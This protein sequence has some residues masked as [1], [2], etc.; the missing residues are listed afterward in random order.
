[1]KIVF[2]SNF[3]NHH[4]KPFSDELFRL[5]PDYYFVETT[6]V[7]SEQKAMGYQADVNPSYVLRYSENKVFCE[8]LVNDADAVIIG[9]APEYLIKNRKKNNKIVI[10]YCERPLKKK[11]TPIRYLK[12]LIGMNLITPFWKPLYML[13]ASAYTASDFRLFGLYIGKTYKW[14]YFTEVKNFVEIDTLIDAKEKK[15]ILWTSRLISWKHPELAVELAEYLTKKN[16]AFDLNIVGSGDQ[17]VK[18]KKMIEERKLNSNV[19]LL[20]MMKNT[21]VRSM[22]EKSEIF[23]STSDR[24]EGWG[25]TVNESMSSACAVV[26]DRQIGSVPFLIQD[27]VN[28]FIYNNKKEFF[29][30]VEILLNNDDMRRNI[31][32]NAYKT[33]RNDWSPEEAAVRF[34]NLAENLIKYG[35][36]DCFKNGPCSRA[37]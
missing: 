33:M 29:E 8:Q 6:D 34:L 3:F 13:C 25:A 27:G 11:L 32:R 26:A 20:G 23:I 1:M 9:S 36:C 16:I 31:S 37:V 10:R 17:D 24:Q 12:Q 18:L 7:P 2:L 5:N 28:G 22:M 30:K 21:Q 4:Q 14:G 19:H 15:T 35:K